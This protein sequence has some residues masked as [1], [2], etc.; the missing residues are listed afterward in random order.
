MSQFTQAFQK[1]ARQMSIPPGHRYPS[2][3]IKDCGK[4]VTRLRT[5]GYHE[6]EVGGA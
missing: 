5:N 6:D 1:L 4:Q 2:Q 3:L